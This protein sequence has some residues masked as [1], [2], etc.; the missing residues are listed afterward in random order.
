[1]ILR[2]NKS[3]LYFLPSKAQKTDLGIKSGIHRTCGNGIP[4]RANDTHGI[5]GWVTSY[6]EIRVCFLVELLLM[7][8]SATLP[9]YSCLYHTPKAL[10]LSTIS[11]DVNQGQRGFTLFPQLGE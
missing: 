4:V 11:F 3:R 5:F 8:S 10:S 6:K 2:H 1:M 7:A 9:K